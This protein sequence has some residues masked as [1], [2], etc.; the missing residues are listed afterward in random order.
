MQFISEIQ[1]EKAAELLGDDPVVFQAAVE[2]FRE[3]EPA[4]I[5]YLFSE[6]TF[7]F[8]DSE[9]EWLLYVAMIILKSVEPFRESATA[10]TE[11]EI[12]DS[13][14]FNWTTIQETGGRNLRDRLNVFFDDTP[15][16][17]LLAFAEDSV[18]DDEDETVSAEGRE[19]LFILLKTI[20][21]VLTV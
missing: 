11:K 17:D 16:E 14:E 20:I 18:I 9:R 15:Q 7:A 8:T 21:D 4:L 13:E 1:I 19:P 12:L 2:S 6:D 5:A 3:K 10:V